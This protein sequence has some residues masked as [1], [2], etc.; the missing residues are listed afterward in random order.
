MKQYRVSVPMFVIYWQVEVKANS[1]LN[2]KYQASN[3]LAQNHEEETR[4]YGSFR[5]DRADVR[6]EILRK[7]EVQE[8]G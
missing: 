3:M 6:G 8:L 5:T 2:A 7:M 4:K 1:E